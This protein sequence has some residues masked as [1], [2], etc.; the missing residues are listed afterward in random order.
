MAKSLPYHKEA[1]QSVLG[2]IFLDPKII[3]SVMDQLD[4]DDFFEQP[5]I[6]IYQAMKDLYQDNHKSS[7]S[8][9]YEIY[10]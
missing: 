4:N 2:A 3:V 10:H 9:W 6:M 8:R 5:H 1:E 7:K